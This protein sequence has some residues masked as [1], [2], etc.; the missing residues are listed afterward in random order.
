MKATL[1]RAAQGVAPGRG[2]LHSELSQGKALLAQAAQ[3]AA[4]T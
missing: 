4:H 1:V 3:L 2:E